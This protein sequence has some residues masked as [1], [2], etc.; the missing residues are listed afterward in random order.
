MNESSGKFLRENTWVIYFRIPC[1]FKFIFRLPSHMNE[2]M[3]DVTIGVVL[4]HP[5]DSLCTALLTT[6]I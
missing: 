4:V 5:Y 1:I 3:A 2:N 6:G